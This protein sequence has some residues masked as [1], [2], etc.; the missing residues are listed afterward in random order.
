MNRESCGR[1]S[2]REHHS[3]RLTQED[4]ARDENPFDAALIR[5]LSELA[6]HPNDS[7]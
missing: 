4:L 5:K 1:D 3:P 6:R 7:I 2:S